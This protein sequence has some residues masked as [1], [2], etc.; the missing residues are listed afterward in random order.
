MFR[1]DRNGLARGRGLNVTFSAAAAPLAPAA[2]AAPLLGS[3]LLECLL[4][5]ILQLLLDVLLIG[6]HRMFE[7]RLSLLGLEWPFVCSDGN[8]RRSLRGQGLGLIEAMHLLVL[9][10]DERNLPSNCRVSID[11]NR[12]AEAFLQRPQMGTFLIE[13]VK[14]DL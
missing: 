7:L 5:L 1:G 14:R 8:C 10:D 6:R 11:H 3:L 2:F 4:L 9:F 13:E 12:D